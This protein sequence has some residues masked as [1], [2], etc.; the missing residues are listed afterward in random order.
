[1]LLAAMRHYTRVRYTGDLVAASIVR[2]ST[3]RRLT[4]QTSRFMS[5]GCGVSVS[6]VSLEMDSERWLVIDREAVSRH[7]RGAQT[8]TAD[9][10]L[11]VR[12]SVS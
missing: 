1:M 6:M 2:R 9:P 7:S 11:I 8:V 4:R 12:Q 3:S 10:S 5:V